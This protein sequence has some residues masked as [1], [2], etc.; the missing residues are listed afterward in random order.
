MTNTNHVLAKNEDEDLTAWV[1]ASEIAQENPHIRAKK[2]EYD[3]RQRKH[4]GL[5]KAG[6]V[7]KFG[8]RYLVHRIRYA[9]WLAQRARGA[10]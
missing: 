3:V 7:L 8:K 9:R 6:A 10:A 2:V 5:E 1:P 4:N